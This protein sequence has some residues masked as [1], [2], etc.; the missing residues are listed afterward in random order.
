MS[1]LNTCVCWGVHSRS[2]PGKSASKHV[3]RGRAHN[4]KGSRRAISA[5]ATL[6]FGPAVIQPE[7]VAGA[8]PWVPTC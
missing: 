3:R 5:S 6:S 4:A 1:S 2:S 8:M 7:P